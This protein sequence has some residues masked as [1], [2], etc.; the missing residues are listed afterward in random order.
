[1][2]RIVIVAAVLVRQAPRAPAQ[3]VMVARAREALPAPA[4]LK[5][6]CTQEGALYS[7]RAR[8][9]SRGTIPVLVLATRAVKR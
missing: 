6:T 2:F 1:M 5:Q 9:K 8:S 4:A 3:A 7:P